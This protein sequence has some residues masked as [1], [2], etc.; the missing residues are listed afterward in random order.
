MNMAEL[1]ELLK[2]RSIDAGHPMLGPQKSRTPAALFNARGPE[3]RL[4]LRGYDLRETSGDGDPQVTPNRKAGCRGM[5][6]HSVIPQSICTASYSIVR[7]YMCVALLPPTSA[8]FAVIENESPAC[9]G[10]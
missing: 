1:P 6:S 4:K 9:A 3:L 8:E 5:G 2:R 7:R 10:L